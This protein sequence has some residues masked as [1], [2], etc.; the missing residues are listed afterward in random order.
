MILITGL[1]GFGYGVGIGSHGTIGL[2]LGPGS[3]KLGSGLM[4]TTS[5]LLGPGIIYCLCDFNHAIK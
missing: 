5:G 3:G 2:I 1:T 4:G